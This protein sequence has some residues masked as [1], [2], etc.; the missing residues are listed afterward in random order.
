MEEHKYLRI[1]LLLLSLIVLYFVYRI[2]QHFLLP[3][4]LAII[5]ATLFFS[6]F[7]WTCQRLQSRRS[8]AAL[9]TCVWVTAIIIVPFVVLVILLAGQMAEV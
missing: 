4:C 1:S 6:V 5:L 2:F 9:L 7:D 8:W 3:I